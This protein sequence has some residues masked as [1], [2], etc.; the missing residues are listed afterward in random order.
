MTRHLLTVWNPSYADSIMDAHLEVLLGLADRREGDAEPED[1][2]V[3][4]AKIKSPNRQQPLPHIADILAIQ[5]QID[6]GEETHLYLTDYRSLYVA[7]LDEITAD[8]VAAETP[9][10]VAHMPRYYVGQQADFWFRLADI[11]LLVADDSV[12]TIEELKKLRNVRYHG[13]PVSLYGGMVELPLIVTREDGVAW[14][15]DAGALTDGRLWAQHDA[16]MRGETERMARELRDN[17]IGRK[18]WVALEPATRNFL[19]SAEAVFRAR[20][21]DPRFD[22][23]GPAIGYTKAVETE[24]NALIFPVLR[25]ALRKAQLADRE[26]VIEGRAVDVGGEV[27]HQSLGTLK[28]LLQRNDIVRGAIRRQLPGDAAWLLDALPSQLAGLVELRNPAAHGDRAS[29]EAVSD[30]REEVLGVGVKG[31][32]VQ[33]TAFKSKFHGM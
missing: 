3:W 12:A 23:S 18:L 24:L 6:R 16:E 19:A 27:R 11:R 14:F 8:D 22:F 17:L 7:H 30:A 9:D 13:R 2:Y 5:E 26:V 31:L 28:N 33:I 25:K 32:V 21:D 1:P 29:R 10:E 4:W 15:S 20:R